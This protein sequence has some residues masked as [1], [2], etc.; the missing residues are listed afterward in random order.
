M[1]VIFL[2]SPDFACDSLQAIHNS[3]H[4]VVAV[5]TQPDKPVGRSDKPVPTKVKQLATRLGLPVYTYEKISRDGVD[6]L[7]KLGADIMVTCAYGQMLSQQVLDICPNGVINVHGSLLP[8][9]RGAAPIQWA[10]INGDKVTGITILKTMIGMDDGPIILQREIKINEYET[11]G[12]LFDRLKVLGAQCIVEALDNI[13]NGTA[14]FT[15]Q[16]ESKAVK[17]KLLK[18][19]MSTLDWSLPNTQVA[20]MIHGLNPWPTAKCTIDG[21]NF[22][23][24]RCELSSL[25]GGSA[26][27]VLVASNKQGLVIR[28]GVG[29]VKITELQPENG[30]R[31]RATDYLNGKAI[32]VGAKVN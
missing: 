22:K 8:K 10:I 27:E 32:K 16:D 21:V 18:P 2:G 29:S 12:E 28:C 15:P 1:K 25:D 13:Q 4:T 23:L 20:N 3:N 31:M 17:C 26:G 7:T 6:E 30:K 19:T 5:V 14:T 24:H 9:Y 11:S